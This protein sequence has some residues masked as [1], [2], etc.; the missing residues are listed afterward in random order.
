MIK[1]IQLSVLWLHNSWTWFLCF[2]VTQ[3]ELK[4]IYFGLQLTPDYETKTLLLCVQAATFTS[5]EKPSLLSSQQLAPS[6]L[7]QW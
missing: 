1:I 3:T 4:Q 7:R 5:A 6:P 2:I